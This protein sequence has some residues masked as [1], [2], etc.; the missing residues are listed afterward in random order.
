VQ[1]KQSCRVFFLLSCL[2]LNTHAGTMGAVAPEPAVKPVITLFG[3]LSIINTGKDQVYIGDDDNIFTYHA[4][5][6]N[7]IEGFYGVCLGLEYP[8]NKP[9]FLFQGGIELNR[10]GTAEINGTHTAGVEPE[11][12]TFYNYSYRFRSQQAL[13]MGKLL[14]TFHQRFHPFILAGIGISENKL[15]DFSV[16]TQEAGNINLTPDFSSHTTQVTG[17]ALGLGLDVTV[18]EHV[19]IG[20]GYRYSGL[21]GSHFDRG[22]VRINQDSFRSPFVL[23]NGHNYSNDFI[24]QISYIA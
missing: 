7:K 8:L 20:G 4:S 11:T 22:Y 12:S 19:R 10:R 13:L 15:S 5:D 17:Y 21:G 24:L 3:G 1:L 6:S 16:S 9:G 23:G 14:G 18:H 2:G